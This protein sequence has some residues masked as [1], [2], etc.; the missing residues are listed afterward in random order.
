MADFYKWDP[1]KL[2]TKVHEMDREHQE[3]IRLMNKVYASVEAKKPFADLKKELTDLGAYTTKHFKDEEAYMEKVKF[4][5]LSTHKIIHTKL[6]EQFTG[7]MTEFEKTKK[8]EDK[9]F[10]FLSVWL[11]SHIMGIDSKYGEHATKAAA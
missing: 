2:S 11:T 8:L 3:L 1:V 10:K 6:L 5:G 9:F 7:Y 4:P